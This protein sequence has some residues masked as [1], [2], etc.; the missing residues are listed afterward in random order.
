MSETPRFVPVARVLEGLAVRTQE[1]AEPPTTTTPFARETIPP[2]LQLTY[3][4]KPH[5]TVSCA[6]G[7]LRHNLE[8][9]QPAIAQG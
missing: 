6:V 5:G 3:E 9:T 7:A 1:P 2:T 4:R 8:E